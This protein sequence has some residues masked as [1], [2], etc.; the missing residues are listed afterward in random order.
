M[1]KNKI[2]N[3]VPKYLKTILLCFMF[4]WTFE[5]K[6]SDFVIIL[7]IVS[8]MQPDCGGQLISEISYCKTSLTILIG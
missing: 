8:L 7:S 1:K 4:T 5:E 3:V 6:Q 2:N